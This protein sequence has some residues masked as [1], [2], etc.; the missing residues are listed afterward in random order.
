MQCLAS[1][2][3]LDIEYKVHLSNNQEKNGNRVKDDKNIET[4]KQ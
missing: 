3:L 1:K 4:N 2:N